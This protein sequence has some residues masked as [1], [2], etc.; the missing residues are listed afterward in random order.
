MRIAQKKKKPRPSRRRRRQPT[1]CTDFYALANAD[2]LKAQPGRRRRRACPRMGQLAERAQQQQRDLLDAAMAVAAGQR[3]EAARRLLGQRPGRS[4]GRSATAPI[5]SRRCWR[6]STRIK[7]AKDVAAGDRRAAPGRHPGR[8]QLRRRHRPAAISTATSATSARAASA[9][10]TRPTTPAPMPTRAR[11]SAAT[12]DYVQ[13][14]LAA[15]RHAAGQARGRSAGGDRPGNAH[16]A[17]VASRWRRCAIRAP[18][19][20]RCRRRTSARPTRACSWPSSSR[21]RASPTTRCRSPTRSCSR[22]STRWSPACKPAQWQAYLRFHVGNAMA[23]Y[24]A[25]AW[26]DAEF[27]FRGR[28]LRGQSRAGAALAAGA[29]CDQHR[30]RPDARPRIRRRATCRPRRKSRAR[31]DRRPKCATRSVAAIDRSPWMGA[32]AK[33]EAKAKLD[34]LKIEIGTP[35]RDLDYTVQPMGRGSFGG[36]MLIASTWRHRE[37]MK[38]I[39]R[40]NADRRWDVLPQQPALAY[41][42]AQNRLIVTAAMLQAPVLDMAQDT[43][44]QYGAFGALVGHELEPRASTTRA[45][46]S[47]PTATVRDWWTPAEAAAWDALGQRVAA[48]YGGYRLS[49]ADGHQGQRPARRATR[50]SPT[51]PASNWHGMPDN[52]ATAAATDDAQAGVLPGL[53]AAVG[54]ADVEPDA[55]TARGRDQRARAGPMARQRPAG[56]PARR[57]ARPS[58]ARPARRCSARGR[59]A[60]QGLALS[61]CTRNEKRRGIPRRFSLLAHDPRPRRLALAERRLPAPVADQQ[62]AEQHAAQVRE[63][64]HARLRSR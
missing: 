29:R 20:R 32:P 13:K 16:R 23:P 3:A 61:A 58:P 15:D 37:E 64:R 49:G 22:N 9:C 26:R 19:T 56:E 35:R 2:W 46:W 27:E 40:G 62:P 54:A 50:T 18:T 43:A 41:D 30:R 5:R 36:N 17:G 38:R 59:A 51:W 12:R 57:S 11:C 39:G 4:R 42:I 6:A 21:R 10:P 47:M 60:G 53:G 24:L 14:I 31:D 34:K 55:A 45:A 28:V 48:Q 33:A 63:V 25:K 7:R 8:V 52:R 44:A 1:A